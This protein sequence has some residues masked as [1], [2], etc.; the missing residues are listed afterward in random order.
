M[1]ENWKP[2]AIALGIF[3]AGLLT[4]IWS[5]RIRIGPLP[6]P[7]IGVMGEFAHGDFMF[8]GAPAPP[9]VTPIPVPEIAQ[10]A[11]Q[12]APA[13]RNIEQAATGSDVQEIEAQLRQSGPVIVEGSLADPASPIRVTAI[14]CSE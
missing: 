6:P 9:T 14:R 1:K 10:R 8:S 13:L 7:G 11:E 2:I 5:Q 12:L 4:G 3:V